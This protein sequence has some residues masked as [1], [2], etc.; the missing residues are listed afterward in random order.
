MILEQTFL[1][2]RKKVHNIQKLRNS[3]GWGE[4]KKKPKQKPPLHHYAK[5]LF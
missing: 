2:R 3:N 5:G 4:G 1:Y